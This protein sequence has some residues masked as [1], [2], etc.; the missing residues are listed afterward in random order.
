MSSVNIE[1]ILEGARWEAEFGEGRFAA[2][3]AIWIRRSGAKDIVCHFD[4][5]EQAYNFGCA[6]LLKHCPDYTVGPSNYY[7]CLIG[8]NSTARV[9]M[10]VGFAPAGA[11]LVTP[12]EAMATAI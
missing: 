9:E 12:E 5:I 4:S 3:V 8:Y 2:G 6:F 10:C 7:T 1:E 11:I